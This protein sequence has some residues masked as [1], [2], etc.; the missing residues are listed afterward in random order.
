MT[1]EALTLENIKKDLRK[2]YYSRI[3]NLLLLLLI[4]P[5]AC[6]I[7]LS[8]VLQFYNPGGSFKITFSI[9]IF[10]ICFISIACNAITIIIDLRR[11]KNGNFTITSDRVVEKKQAVAGKKIRDSQPYR[12]IFA[13]SGEY[14]IPYGMNYQWSDLFATS[15]KTLYEYTEIN[16]EFY[17][18]SLGEKKNI[19]AYRKKHFELK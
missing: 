9:V 5:L 13:K 12:L 1:K 4:T 10:A 16:E 17:V 6:L 18:I 7:A 19:V 8:A 2:H 15:A 11:T 3:K 14:N